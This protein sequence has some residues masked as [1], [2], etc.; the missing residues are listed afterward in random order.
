MGVWVGNGGVR[1]VYCRVLGSGRPAGDGHRICLRINIFWNNLR[2][3]EDG[4]LLDW[5]WL[6][7]LVWLVR[8]LRWPLQRLLVRL[9]RVIAWLLVRPVMIIVHRI[10]GIRRRRARSWWENKR[11]FG[12]SQATR[13]SL[14]LRVKVNRLDSNNLRSIHGVLYD[15][16]DIS[17]LTYVD[18]RRD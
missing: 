16:R 2:I 8:W 12:F 6:W 1:G 9:V 5:L 17:D 4:L 14:A 3:L 18:S 11:V 15:R 13:A 7:L 10:F